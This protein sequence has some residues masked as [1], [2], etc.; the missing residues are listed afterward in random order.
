MNLQPVKKFPLLQ[1]TLVFLLLVF[2]SYLRFYDNGQKL[3]W[4]DEIYT[5]FW[6][7]G[8]EWRLAIPD[9][10]G[11]ALK[12]RDVQKLVRL[13]ENSNVPAIIETI[14]RDDPQHTPLYFVAL[15]FWARLV[16]DSIGALRS[17][18]AVADLLILPLLFWLCMELFRSA[19]VGWIAVAL[20]AVSPFHIVYSQ[21][22]RPY[23]LWMLSIVFASAMLLWTLRSPRVWKWGLYALAVGVGLYTQL[24]F[25]FVV[26]AHAA[27]VSGTLWLQRPSDDKKRAAVFS[28]YL[29]ATTGAILLFIPWIWIILTHLS[30]ALGHVSWSEQKVGLAHLAGMWAYNYSA[31]FLDTNQVLKFI[32]K[33]GFMVYGAFFLR[34]LVLVPA[35]LAVLYLLR[36]PLRK[37]SL[38]LLPLILVPF[39]GMALPDLIWGGIRSGG[40]NRY[41]AASFLGLEI[42][43]AYWLAMGLDRTETAKRNIGLQATHR[44]AD[45][46]F[47]A[48][49][50]PFRSLRAWPGLG[51]RDAMARVT[52]VFILAMGILSGV[53]FRQ[54][55]TWW[56]KT[57]GHFNMEVAGIINKEKNPLLI[58]D[59]VQELISLSYALDQQAVLMLYTNRRHPDIPQGYSAVFVISPT[60][61][62][63][64]EIRTDYG[65]MLDEV[66]PRAGLYRASA[67]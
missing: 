8:H 60:Q 6:Y 56:H 43:L 63:Q 41:L 31:L 65:L 67:P 13:D 16:G 7:S 1:T 53:I 29:L 14:I 19:R 25:C 3:F 10:E 9:L 23:T 34:A 4:F 45:A 15:R 24:L 12:P 50:P 62:M 59:S 26:L 54:A 55:G 61:R 44:R 42:A 28:G 57:I 22:A 40:G 39:L 49:N 11:H 30:T 20:V 17:F 33:P 64:H 21:E 52:F 32:D 27:Y 35:A 37:P 47:K 2:G 51:N 48:G 18:S 38:F 58:S 5:G 36:N 46:D 66:L